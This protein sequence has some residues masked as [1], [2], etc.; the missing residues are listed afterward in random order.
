MRGQ[1]WEEMGKVQQRNEGEAHR[2]ALGWGA[3]DLEARQVPVELGAADVDCP[4]GGIES[5]AAPPAS[6]AAS[7]SSTGR[8]VDEA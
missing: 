5:P 2:K 8:H 3:L 7:S 1:R 6:A 4:S